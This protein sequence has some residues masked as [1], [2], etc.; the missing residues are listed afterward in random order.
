MAYLILVRHGQS[1]WNKKG[2]WTG[3]RDIP[4]TQ[5]G[6]LEAEKAA[7][8][9]SDIKL[10]LGYTSKL[11]RSKETLEI[12]KKI[13]KNSEL[14]TI[15]TDALNERDYGDL[16]GKNKWEIKKQYGNEIFQKIRRNW[17]YT[18]PNGETLKDVYNRAIPF[19]QKE[20]LPNLINGKNIVLVA[21][22]NSLRALVKYLENIPENKIAFLEI[23]TGEVYIYVIDTRGKIV[24]KEKRE[25][26]PNAM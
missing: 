21:S 19:Y 5:Q 13:K 15:Q 1:E 12:I 16:T 8:S 24:F 26:R 14:P 20:I 25:S 10:N 7:R 9:I 6:K 3:L 23:A 11:Q 22:G 17:D 4:L 2:L 18:I